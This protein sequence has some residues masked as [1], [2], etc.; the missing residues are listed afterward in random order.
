[1]SAGDTHGSLSES[2]Y[3]KIPLLASANIPGNYPSAKH[4]G[5]LR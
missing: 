2:G 3:E 5:M 4:A 1:M